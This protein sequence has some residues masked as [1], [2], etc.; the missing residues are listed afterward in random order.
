[1]HS[2]SKNADMKKNVTVQPHH[3]QLSKILQYSKHTVKAITNERLYVNSQA[4]APNQSPLLLFHVCHCH[5]RQGGSQLNKNI[6]VGYSDCFAKRKPQRQALA[7]K[8]L[9]TGTCVHSCEAQI[10]YLGSWPCK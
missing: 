3:T 7:V 10:W 8:G 9:G 4:L 5:R 1:M 2:N 6:M